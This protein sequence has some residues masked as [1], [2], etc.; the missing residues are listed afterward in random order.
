[1]AGGGDLRVPPEVWSPTGGFYA[2]PRRWKR[3]TALV[4][5]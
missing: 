2:D 1:M 3:N 4:A 5:A